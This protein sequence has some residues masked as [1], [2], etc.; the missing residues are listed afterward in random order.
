MSNSWVLVCDKLRISKSKNWTFF[1]FSVQAI[2]ILIFTMETVSQRQVSVMQPTCSIYK[3]FEGSFSKLSKERVKKYH[4][5]FFFSPRIGIKKRKKSEFM[6]DDLW[7]EGHL[8]EFIS[9]GFTFC[10][11]YDL[12]F[13]ENIITPPLSNMI[14]SSFSL[15]SSYM[16][17][18]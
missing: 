8:K 5:S 1:P 14:Y 4:L 11:Y 6:F 10:C 9:A 7:E 15:L 18:I 2:L 17:Q 12:T 3:K 16:I 13:P